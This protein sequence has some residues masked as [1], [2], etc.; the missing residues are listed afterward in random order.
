MEAVGEKFKRDLFLTARTKAWELC[1]QLA[2]Q[3]T[4]GMK[5]ADL[6]EELEALALKEGVEKWW[7]PTKIRFAKNTRCSF[8]DHSDDSVTLA[9]DDIFFLDIGPVFHDHEGDVGQ[10]FCLKDGNILQDFKNPAEVLFHELKDFWKNDGLS[11]EALY[12]RACEIAELQGYEFNLRM[13]GH[14]LSDFP[15]ALHHKGAL[16]DFE[17]KP[18]NDRW[19]L[20]VHLLDNSKDCGYF[21][22][23]LLL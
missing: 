4:V 6:K 13:A 22:E 15:H 3:V 23:D 7:H 12:K 9:K 14:R 1:Y 8:R 21:Y 20:E 16:K 17:E 18:Q 10:T 5:E 11:G 2:A 19:V